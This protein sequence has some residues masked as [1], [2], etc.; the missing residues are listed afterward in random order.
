MDPLLSSISYPSILFEEE[1]FKMWYGSNLS[2]GGDQSQMNH[3][4]K[5][6]ESADGLTWKR[7]GQIVVD[8]MHEKELALLSNSFLM[9]LTGAVLHWN[10]FKYGFHC[11]C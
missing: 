1:K 9:H 10:S 7:S 6:A 5:Y 8:L 11:N 2:W 4:F 3:V